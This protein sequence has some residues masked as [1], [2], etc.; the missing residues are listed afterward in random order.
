MV[1]RGVGDKYYRYYIDG[2]GCDTV[3]TVGT[4][5]HNKP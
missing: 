5:E 2:D 4:I 1:E 3:Q